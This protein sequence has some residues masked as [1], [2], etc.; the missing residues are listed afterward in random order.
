[1][2]A[3]EWVVVALALVA[4]V[5]AS[6]AFLVEPR[7][8][9]VRERE[10][11]IR[12]LPR[13]LDGLRIA[14]LSDL[15]FSTRDPGVVVRA[16]DATLAARPDLVAVTGDLTQR[17]TER[18]L[19]ARELKR[20]SSLHTFVILGNHDYHS[21]RDKAHALAKAVSRAGVKILRDESVVVTLRG[22]SVRVIGLDM[23]K[24]GGVRPL[25]GVIDALPDDQI[26]R[27]LLTH[28]PASLRDLRPGDA[29]VALIGHTHGGQI[30]IPGLT[31]A[32]IHWFYDGIGD[33]VV[34]RSG[35]PIH[36]SRGLATSNIAARFLRRPEVTFLTL[37]SR[38]GQQGD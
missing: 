17:G 25:R 15:H 9:R 5:L 26:P 27:I 11:A 4:C 7:W 22:E 33:G 34:Y 16:I 28:S 24:R 8:L 30:F 10:L 38:P 21:G 29:D 37:R 13:A 18:E 36:V 32:Y 2:T 19:A 23:S 35:V 20:L 3:A 14:H 6:Y 1:L 31:W 12:G